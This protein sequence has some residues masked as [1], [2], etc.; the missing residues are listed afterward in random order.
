MDFSYPNAWNTNA[1]NFSVHFKPTGSTSDETD[2]IPW[3]EG[4]TLQWELM[5]VPSALLLFSKDGNLFSV[6]FQVSQLITKPG[7][8]SLCPFSPRPCDPILLNNPPSRGN[9]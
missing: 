1:I 2:E 9:I 3:T 6:V 5:F 4:L 7:L 8:S